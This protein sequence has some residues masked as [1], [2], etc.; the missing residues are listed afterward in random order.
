MYFFPFL[1]I[2]HF[3][4]T[5][6]PIDNSSMLLDIDFFFF[7]LFRSVP[8]AYRTSQA[9]GWIRAVAASLYHSHSK[10]GSKLCPWHITAHSNARY[11]THWVR[12]RIKPVSS[13]MLVMSVTAEPWWEILYVNFLSLCVAYKNM[14]FAYALICTNSYEWKKYYSSIDF[15]LSLNV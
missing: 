5:P 9:R 3:H 11:L 10:V 4:L 13:W 15:S 12:P 1:H 14:H 8:A 6:F 7:C 2:L